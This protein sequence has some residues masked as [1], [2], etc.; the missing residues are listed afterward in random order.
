[1]QGSGM[2]REGEKDQGFPVP[3]LPE[4]ILS[5]S[6]KAIQP[7]LRHLEPPGFLILGCRGLGLQGGLGWED[8]PV[9]LAPSPQGYC[10]AP[11]P[12][13]R[14]DCFLLGGLPWTLMVCL[15]PTGLGR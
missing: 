3:C 7:T 13:D 6:S 11:P 14:K 4:W 10:Q 1:M 5:L 9:A 8:G 12:G 15:T 2:D